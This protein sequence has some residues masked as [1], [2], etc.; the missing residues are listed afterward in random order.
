MDNQDTA[1]ELASTVISWSGY[2]LAATGVL[3]TI[4]AIVFFF[5]V[6]PRI[7]RKETREYLQSEQGQELLKDVAK[8]IMNDQLANIDKDKGEPI[9]EKY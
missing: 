1:L 9:H 6:Q 3:L 7:V 5:G 2:L 4:S 8:G